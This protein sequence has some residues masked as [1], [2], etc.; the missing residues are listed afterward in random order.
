[1]QATLSKL[2][3]H[4]ALLPWAQTLQP[5]PAM[6][7]LLVLTA[8]VW[9][10]VSLGVEWRSM[11]LVPGAEPLQV[12]RVT[13]GTGRLSLGLASETRGGRRTAAQWRKREKAVAVINASMFQNDLRTSA[14]HLHCGAHVNQAAWSSLYQSVLAFGPRDATL[15]EFTL[16]DLDQS[17]AKE[18]LAKYD[19]VVQN[20]RLI[21]A[22]GESVWRAP[23]RQWAESALAL[24]RAGRLLL[25]FSRT[26]VSMDEL[27]KK[28]L[29]SDL[30][31]VRAMHLD[32]G[33]EAS[34]SLKA[35]ALQLDFVAADGPVELPNV[36]LVH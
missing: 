1:M 32:G 21:R 15:P 33:K 36:L 11:P 35:G 22:P 19:C 6:L 18:T 9:Q 31:I 20:L 12:V 30:E 17:G 7:T 24:D 34:L 5:L 3:W 27:V 26:P 28:L 13:P 8:A 14:G 16:V 10:P 29:A 25:I 4:R 23:P 2:D